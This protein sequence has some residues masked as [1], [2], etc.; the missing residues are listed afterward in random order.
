MNN[1]S[2]AVMTAIG[3]MKQHETQKE[4]TLTEGS[5]YFD[6]HFEKKCKLIFIDFSDQISDGELPVFSPV[7]EE[8]RIEQE[9][10][11]MKNKLAQT[12]R[13][14]KE[15]KKHRARSQAENRY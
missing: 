15:Q 6:T 4:S 11:Q 7:N 10:G 12:A 13:L 1:F 2:A 9:I 8:H 5:R 14:I 3:N